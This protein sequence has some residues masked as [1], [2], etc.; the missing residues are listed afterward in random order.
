MSGRRSCFIAF[1][2]L[3]LTACSGPSIFLS[4]DAEMPDVSLAG[5]SFS[6]PGLVEHGLTI[7]LR[8][9]NPNA[10]DIPVDGLNFAL[11][12]DNTA[13]VQGLT[14]EDFTLPK[15][16]RNRGAGR[17]HP[18]DRRLD[19]AGRRHRHGQ[20]SRLQ[21]HRRGR[22]RL[23]VCRSRSLPSR[24]QA[25]AARFSRSHRSCADW[26]TDCLEEGEQLA[27]CKKKTIVKLQAANLASTITVRCCR[28]TNSFARRQRV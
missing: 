8:L 16:R 11:D 19:R 10:F 26:L 24:R 14:K 27:P 3:G 20:T 1:A 7:Q 6:E 25:G 21:A 28:T 13:F 4:T 18:A 23:M 2:M 22:D 9:K 17:H 5:L 12:V 15:S